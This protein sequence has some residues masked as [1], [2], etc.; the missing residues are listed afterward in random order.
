MKVRIDLQLESG[1]CHGSMKMEISDDHGQLISLDDLPQGTVDVPLEIQW[2]NKICVQLSGKDKD[3][4]T[5]MDDA[6]NITEN[7]FVRLIGVRVNGIPLLEKSLYDICTW[8]PQKGDHI[9]EVF[10]DDN[11]CAELLFDG[12]NPMRFMIDLDNVLY[13]R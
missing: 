9:Q 4:D 12:I 7:K 2:P 6:G 10:W 5:E 3:N 13:F 1:R 8:R 11:G